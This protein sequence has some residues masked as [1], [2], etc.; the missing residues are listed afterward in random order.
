MNSI[1]IESTNEIY[2]C[3]MKATIKWSSIKFNEFQIFTHAVQG[4][5][6]SLG[7]LDEGDHW[8]ELLSK[9]RGYRFFSIACPLSEEILQGRLS[10]LISYLQIT[11][12]AFLQSRPDTENRYD[13]LLQACKHLQSI[14]ISRLLAKVVEEI[15]SLKKHDETL[16]LVCETRFIA[17][18]ENS[19]R[20]AGIKDVEVA[21]PSY[22]RSDS[23]YENML[24]IGPTRW[25]PPFV[26]SAP[27]AKTIHILKYTWIR[28]KWSHQPTFSN[29]L[30]QKT[31][32]LMQT[33]I[34]EPYEV[35]SFEADTLLPPA[36]DFKSAQ[37]QVTDAGI[38]HNAVDYIQ[39][40]LF[41]LEENWVVPLSAEDD[42]TALVINLSEDASP[43]KKMKIREI[44]AGMFLL[45]R[46]SGGGDFIIPVADQIMGSDGPKARSHQKKW[47]SLLRDYII[48]NGYDLTIKQL[49]KHGS[50][51][52]NYVNLRNWMFERSIKTEYKNDF[53]AIMRMIG[54]EAESDLYWNLMDRID[55]AHRQAGHIIGKMLLEKVRKSD[56]KTLKKSGKIEFEL[57]N[58]THI[59][60]TAFQV[61]EI[62]PDI[63]RILPGQLGNPIKQA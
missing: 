49:K 15:K 62:S 7:A 48:E 11:R 22:L 13:A 42:A 51:R 18:A 25:F 38:G 58:E 20:S 27:R 34:S 23:S 21:S 35:S 39:A 10:E 63:I 56:L 14:E 2:L 32:K 60:I 53:N 61:V 3:S 8:F 44:E 36:F 24:V 5:M 1:S 46:T 57:E 4:L 16:V 54:L 55:H 28:D 41:L 19:L 12:N 17:D 6:N 31:S 50:A 26:F 37:R 52:A 30:R 40:K 9:I 59:S 33:S 43:V 45:L 29:P 47:K